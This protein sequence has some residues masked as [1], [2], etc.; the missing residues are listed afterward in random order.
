MTMTTPLRSPRTTPAR[1]AARARRAMPAWLALVAA[2]GIGLAGCGSLLGPASP[3]PQRFS[4]DDDAAAS[5][6]PAAVV[7]PADAPVLVVTPSSAAPGFASDRMIYLRSP[8]QPEPYAQHAWVDA[9]ARLLVPLLVGRLQRTGRFAAVVTTPGSA[10][11]QVQLDTQ[12][13]RLQHELPGGPGRVRFTLRATLVDKRGTSQRVR[14]RD[15]EAVVPTE[16][17]DAAGA[18]KAARAAV[19]E[20]LA[21]LADFCTSQV[22]ASAAASAAA[23]G[24]GAPAAQ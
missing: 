16:S 5:E 24:R 15:F 8:Q 18:A 19:K 6:V 14:V 2:A 21:Q 1:A 22:P 23:P 3:P 9:P 12:V 17:D 20:V 4:L 11:G 7:A 10:V 13:L